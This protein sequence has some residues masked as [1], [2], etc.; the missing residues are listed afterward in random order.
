MA[1]DLARDLND[2]DLIAQTTYFLGLNEFSLDHFVQAQQHF[3]AAQA[4][5]RAVANSQGEVNCLALLGG[6]QTRQGNYGSAVNY[7]REG[8]EACRR[9]GWR[10]RE[11]AILGDLGTTLFDVGDYKA[12]RSHHLQA[13]EIARDVGDREGQA[14]SLDTLGLVQHHLG[15]NDAA[16][17]S[18]RQALDLQREIRDSRGQG[19]TL[20]HLG[21]A[22]AD[23][24]DWLSAEAVFSLA[25]SLRRGL[26]DNSG[27]VMDDL[28]GLARVALAKDDLAQATRLVE[29][30]LTWIAADGADRIEYPVLVYLI[31]YRVLEACA[32]QRPDERARAQAVL[33]KGVALLQRRAAAIMDPALRQQF[34]ENVPFNRELMAAAAAGA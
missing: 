12:A 11:A 7:L 33:Q 2:P 30:I 16:L 18:F 19:Y 28:A 10:A 6:I 13:L 14:I 29:G 5:Y 22:L 1:L 17:T 15:Q 23:G 8:L 24:G 26:D 3:E 9:I 21:Y 32:R 34:L 25:L 27:V 4:L 31:C 20:T